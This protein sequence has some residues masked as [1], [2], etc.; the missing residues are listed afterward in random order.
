MSVLK[1]CIYAT[2]KK[3]IINKKLLN[4]LSDPSVKQDKGFSGVIVYRIISRI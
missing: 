3:F 1:Y 4:I 2:S